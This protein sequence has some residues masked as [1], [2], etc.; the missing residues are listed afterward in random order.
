MFP[1]NIFLKP[2]LHIELNMPL[3]RFLGEESFFREIFDK[4]ILELKEKAKGKDRK[5]KEEK[6]CKI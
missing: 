5:R 4:V 2:A 1:Q 3:D 6:V